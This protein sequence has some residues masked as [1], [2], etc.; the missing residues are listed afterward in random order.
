MS[1]QLTIE[2]V[3]SLWEYCPVT[4]IIRWKK[5]VGSRAKAGSV[6][7]TMDLKGYVVITYKGKTYKSH[8]IAWALINGAW[9]EFLIDHKNG[10]KHDNSIDNLREVDKSGNQQNMRKAQA[11]NSTGLIGVTKD[12]NCDKFRATI[13]VGGK[14]IY[15][16]LY[17]TPEEAFGVYLDAKRNLHKTCTI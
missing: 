10:V 13:V 1:L 15:L 17:N 11:R 14:P 12:S 16:G 4:G 3:S 6:A 5:S 9:P 2:E 7:G 8:R